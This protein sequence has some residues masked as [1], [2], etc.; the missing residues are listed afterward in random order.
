MGSWI[1][2]FP[3]PH[4]M[5]AWKPV[6]ANRS[7]WHNIPEKFHFHIFLKWSVLFGDALSC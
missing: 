5:T 7:T 6:G 2:L 1:S 4:H 3:F